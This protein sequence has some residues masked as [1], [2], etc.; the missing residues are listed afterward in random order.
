M[1]KEPDTKTKQKETASTKKLLELLSHMLPSA[2]RYQCVSKQA[3]RL[4]SKYIVP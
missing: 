4:L 1:K 3:E 2:R